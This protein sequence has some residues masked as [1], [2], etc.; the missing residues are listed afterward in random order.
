MSKAKKGTSLI[1]TLKRQHAPVE[2]PFVQ[3]KIYGKMLSKMEAKYVEF[4]FT[5][6]TYAQ[7]F[8]EANKDIIFDTFFKNLQ[9][10][11]KK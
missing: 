1:N 2:A 3:S 8:K 5:N 7:L 11:E 10:S 9:A 4:T 6:D